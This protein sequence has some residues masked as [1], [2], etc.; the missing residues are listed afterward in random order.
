MKLLASGLT[1]QLGAGLLEAAGATDGDV[2]LIALMRPAARRTPEQ[3]LKRLGDLAAAIDR[4]IGGDVRAPNW[5]LT[6]ADL[7]RLAPDIRIVLNLAGETN[8]AASQ[9]QLHAINVNGA[10]AGYDV[11]TE[12]QRLSGTP[13][14]YIYIS[15]IHVC[16]ERSGWIAE[17]PVSAD[18]DR[19]AYEHSK[20]I[21]EC[22]LLERATATGAPALMIARAGGLLGSARTGTTLRRNSLYVLADRI[23]RL[24][25]NLL[26]A[27]PR[28]RVDMLPRDWAGAMLLDLAR[29]LDATPPAK[30]EIVHLCAGESAPTIASLI[31]A[32]DAVDVWERRAPIRPA[33]LP[34]ALTPLLSRALERAAHLSPE[35]RSALIAL[36]YINFER[37]FERHRLAARLTSPPP[38]VTAEQ[39]ARLTFELPA[40]E[41]SP[42]A[43]ATSLA[44]LSA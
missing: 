1:G 7:R 44:R 32:I 42:A 23:E 40:A 25:F 39:I 27:R 11:A 37:L 22:L 31:S 24:P 38:Q 12:L 13:T 6:T 10:L 36:R 41:H 35:T 14:T 2:R 28:A 34:R 33:T 30:A 4:P 9:Q 26:P 15:S 20:W 5:G 16:G 29:S 17:N 18:G 3:R 43:A 21:A 8:W 19:T